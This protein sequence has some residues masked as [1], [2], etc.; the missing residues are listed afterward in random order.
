MSDKLISVVMPVY[1]E[2]YYLKDTVSSVLEQKKVDIEFIIVDSSTDLSVWDEINLKD[3]RIKYFWIEK[4]GI[5]NALNFG[6]EKASGEYIARIDSDDLM[7]EDRLYIQQTYLNNH[8]DVSL[9]GSNAYR[10]NE[11]GEIFGKTKLKCE[12][13]DIKAEL[14]FDSA[15]YHP[16]V[17]LRRRL[18]DEG[19][20]YDTRCV[21][22]DYDLWTRIALNY[23]IEN[24]SDYLLKYRVHNESLSKKVK[25]IQREDVA[26]TSMRYI[27]TLFKLDMHE[28][29]WHDTCNIKRY[30]NVDYPTYV[31]KQVKLLK[32]IWEA[33]KKIHAVDDKILWDELEQRWN[34]VVIRYVS[35]YGDSS[36][37]GQ[38]FWYS[39]HNI[40]LL[41]YYLNK[42]EDDFISE[43]YDELEKL[44]TQRNLFLQKDII[45]AIYG[46]GVSGEKFIGE[47][48]D[49][50]AYRKMFNWKLVKMYDSLPKSI[51]IGGRI[52]NSNSIDD[53]SVNDF[54][55]IVVTPK[56]FGA[57][58][59]NLLERGV[60][61]RKIIAVQMFI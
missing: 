51:E 45:Y 14:L 27:S 5:A 2:K 12:Y 37:V 40:K 39:D 50:D 32:N 28:Y 25:D 33:N 49:S 61:E 53:I 22:E 43:L 52:M 44:E 59:K 20:R 8:P 38:T 9:I 29:S 30:I 54:D 21:A 46:L 6:L 36:N 1:N 55:Y 19:F 18:I 24:I 26:K 15:L 41:D 7:C 56:D 16:S 58:K 3:E 11:S 10:I 60:E 23:K 34:W 31:V 48:V 4:N 17:M 13:E 47:W 42:C 57:I 35:N